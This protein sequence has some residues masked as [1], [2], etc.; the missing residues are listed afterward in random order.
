MRGQR[1]VDLLA[2]R[3]HVPLRSGAVPSHWLT[4]GGRTSRRS[5]LRQGKAATDPVNA[6]LNY[7]YAVAESEA[8]IAC[9]TFGLDPA[10]GFG[11]GQHR[12]M[13]SLAFDIMEPLRPMG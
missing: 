4:F 10:L 13:D 7:G 6:M 12:K 2:G 1:G 5:P 9:Y 8:R 3:V 11:H